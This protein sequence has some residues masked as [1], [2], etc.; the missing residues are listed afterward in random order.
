MN[1]S[2]NDDHDKQPSFV[3]IDKNHWERNWAPGVG[4]RPLSLLNVFNRDAIALLSRPLHGTTGA[5]VVEIGFVPGK[6]LQFLERHFHAEC[7]GYDYSESGCRTASRFLGAQR[8]NVQVHC[9]DVLA[10]PPDASHRARLVYSIGVVEHFADPMGMIRAHLEPLAE[11]G[12]AII[13]LPNYQGLNLRIQSRLDPDNIAIHNL[14]S[15]TPEFWEKHGRQFP[16]YEFTTRQFGRLNPWMFSL[17]RLG[18]A[19]KLLQL[20][21]NFAGFLLPSHVKAWASMF[22]VEIRRR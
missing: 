16:R 2:P 22:V 8:A 3:T 17:P 13:I 5:T 7:H 20:A 15:M 10:E 11:D 14:D 19:G 12:V 9:Q 18:K 1:T 6:F 4:A 21:L